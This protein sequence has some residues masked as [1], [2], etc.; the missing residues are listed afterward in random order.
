MATPRLGTEDIAGA[1]CAQVAWVT[2]TTWL[3]MDVAGSPGCDKPTHVSPASPA[4]LPVGSFPP[5]L[6]P[7]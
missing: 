3:M 7:N 4:L 2:P 5:E 6:L 1:L